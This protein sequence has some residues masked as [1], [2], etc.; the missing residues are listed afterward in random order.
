MEAHKIRFAFFLLEKY[1][2][3]GERRGNL[4]FCV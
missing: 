1:V 2:S 3:V 4:L